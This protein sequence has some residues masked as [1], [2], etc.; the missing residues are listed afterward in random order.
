MNFEMTKQEAN[1]ILNRIKFGGS[2]PDFIIDQALIAT[3][4]LY[5]IPENELC[6]EQKTY[7]GLPN[8]SLPDVRSGRWNG[9]RSALESI[10]AWQRAGYQSE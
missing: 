7:G 4:D 9:G 6:S 3:G 2:F 10:Q 5:A 8:D 1:E